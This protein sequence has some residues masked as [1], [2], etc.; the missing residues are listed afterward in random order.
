MRTISAGVMAR[1]AVLR[2]PSVIVAVPP[3]FMDDT[4]IFF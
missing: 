3:Q 1:L 2:K 4:L